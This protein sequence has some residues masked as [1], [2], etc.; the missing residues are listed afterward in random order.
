MKRPTAL[1]DYCCCTLALSRRAAVA[2]A[3]FGGAA[4]NSINGCIAS[5]HFR[6]S[7]LS[8]AAEQR[9]TTRILNEAQVCFVVIDAASPAGQFVYSVFESFEDNAA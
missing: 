3:A 1:S 4:H 2:A 9:R 8:A 7:A 5:E 6:P